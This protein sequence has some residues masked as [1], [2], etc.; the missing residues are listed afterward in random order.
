MGAL[1]AGHAALIQRA[2]QLA[3][4]DGFVVVS[5]FVNPTQ[6]GPREDLSRYPRPF[7]EDRTLC[8]ALGVDLLFHPTAEEMYPEGYST[9]VD[10]ERV[11]QPLCGGSRPGHFRGVCTVVLKLLQI[12]SPD[13][14]VFGLKDFQQCAVVR[15]MVRDLNIGVQIVPVETVRE[16]DGL[17]LSSRNRYLSTEERDQAPVL[18]CALL[19]AEQAFKGGQTSSARLRQLVIRMIETAPLARVDYVEVSDADSLE[20]LRLVQGN[21]VI[22]VAV[23]F[24]KTRLID[25]LWIR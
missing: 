13:S 8:A 21:A 22:A 6:F 18:R 16:A 1:H 11:S 19:A 3:G 23:F 14:A 5:I 24:G 4:R 7:A 25:N 12:T 9:W 20:P 17:A 10:E 2:R 15:Q